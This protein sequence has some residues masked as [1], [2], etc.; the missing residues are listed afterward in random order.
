MPPTEGESP[1]LRPG[2]ASKVTKSNIS[3]PPARPKGQGGHPRR[4]MGW[5]PPT[6]VLW[7]GAAP[8]VGAVHAA[9]S[10]GDAHSVALRGSQPEEPR[11]AS[12]VG[13]KERLQS[14]PRPTGRAEVHPPRPVSPHDFCAISSVVTAGFPALCWSPMETVGRTAAWNPTAPSDPGGAQG[15]RDESMSPRP[16]Q[17]DSPRLAEQHGPP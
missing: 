13:T 5:L 3:P 6:E 17:A 11:S 4:W 7:V 14:S 15:C 1:P 9:L 2:G 8:W 10:R 12:K 16:C